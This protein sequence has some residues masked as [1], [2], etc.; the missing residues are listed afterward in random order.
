MNTKSSEFKLDPIS[1]HTHNV[2][3]CSWQ[4][5]EGY[6]YRNL[7]GS[8]RYVLSRVS[9]EYRDSCSVRIVAPRC[10]NSVGLVGYK[11]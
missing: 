6:Y 11:L 10:C 2:W 5:F 1:S 8:D 3:N 4:Y 9:H 7:N